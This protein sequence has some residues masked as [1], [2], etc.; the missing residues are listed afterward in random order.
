MCR[1]GCSVD[2]QNSSEK[3]AAVLQAA[4]FR[5]VDGSYES[6]S[7]REKVCAAAGMSQLQNV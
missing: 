2:S 5:N 6:S 3:S 4:H 7:P 1:R